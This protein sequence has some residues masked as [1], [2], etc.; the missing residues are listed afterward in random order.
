MYGFRRTI[1]KS[2][3]E[4]TTKKCKNRKIRFTK[5]YPRSPPVKTKNIV[6]ENPCKPKHKKKHLYQTQK[7]TL[8]AQALVGRAS[9]TRE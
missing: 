7:K 4:H 3:T 8:V 1:D 5:I 2:T 9:D 6:L